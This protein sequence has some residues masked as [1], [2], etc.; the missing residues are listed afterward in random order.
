M[1]NS[2][3]KSVGKPTVLFVFRWKCVGGGDKVMGSAHRRNS[4]STRSMIKE[5]PSLLLGRPALSSSSTFQPPCLPFVSFTCDNRLLY[6]DNTDVGCFAAKAV[7]ELDK[8]TS[9]RQSFTFGCSRTSG[10]RTPW[11]C[12]LDSLV[13][14]FQIAAHFSSIQISE[15]KMAVQS[16]YQLVCW[17]CDYRLVLLSMYS[18]CVWTACYECRPFTFVMI[19]EH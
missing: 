12:Q 5:P 4:F 19:S 1:L 2:C 6:L 18:F 10:G 11:S 15:N 3:S 9:H 13:P 8:F 17:G 14:D 16:D 7:G